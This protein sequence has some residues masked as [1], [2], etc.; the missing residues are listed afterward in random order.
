MRNVPEPQ[1]QW[2]DPLAELLRQRLG[3]DQLLIQQLRIEVGDHR[4]GAQRLADLGDDADRPVALD[5][6]LAHRLPSADDDARA[7]AAFAIA[8]VIAPMPPMA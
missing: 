2:L 8:W 7:A 6:D 1:R 3:R 4:R 5:D